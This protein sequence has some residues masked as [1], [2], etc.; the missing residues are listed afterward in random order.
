MGIANASF[1]MLADRKAGLLNSSA[2]YV[3]GHSQAVPLA[4]AWSSK[5]FR[6]FTW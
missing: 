1:Q 2:G 5:Q 6:L 3:A 4:N